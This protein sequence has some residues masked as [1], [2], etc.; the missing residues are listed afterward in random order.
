MATHSSILAWEI[1]WT[2]GLGKVQPMGSQELDMTQQLNH[3]TNRCVVA[4]HCGFNFTFL[5]ILNM[6]IC[7]FKIHM[8]SLLQYLFK[9][10]AYFFFFCQIGS[11]FRVLRVLYIFWCCN[12]CVICKYSSC[13]FSLSFLFSFQCL[14][15]SKKF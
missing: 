6:F 5:M 7:L 12:K 14:S 4:S 15:Q 11:L 9:S 8:S 2:E 3:Q 1:P 10:F 13:S